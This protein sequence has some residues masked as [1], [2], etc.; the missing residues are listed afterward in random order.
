MNDEGIQFVG[1]SWAEKNDYFEIENLWCVVVRLFVHRYRYF[2]I[3][4]LL[5]GELDFVD[6]LVLNLQYLQVLNFK[7]FVV[8]VIIGDYDLDLV[9]V[10]LWVIYLCGVI[11]RHMYLLWLIMLY[12]ILLF[13]HLKVFCLWT[14]KIFQTILQKVCVLRLLV[15]LR[16]FVLRMC[17]KLL[18]IERKEI[19]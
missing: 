12:C 6:D 11:I 14:W 18:L 8:I 10:V 17:Y 1:S 13:V 3:V 16:V 4:V 2:E 9:I 15:Y 19:Q 7:S 5:N